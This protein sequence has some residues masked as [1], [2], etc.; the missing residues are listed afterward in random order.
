M[1]GLF[2]LVDQ[3][4]DGT[5]EN[6]F[7]FVRPP[8]HHA[9]RDRAMG[10]CRFNNVALGARYCYPESSKSEMM[11][12]YSKADIQC[13]IINEETIAADNAIGTLDDAAVRALIDSINTAY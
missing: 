1:G 13:G 10:F 8:G 7:A 5:I 2:S 11:L 9:E 12:V 6:G 4:F 3:I